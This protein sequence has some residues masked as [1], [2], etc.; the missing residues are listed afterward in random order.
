MRRDMIQ[1]LTTAVDAGNRAV[2]EGSEQYVISGERNLLS[3]QDLSQDMNRLRQLLRIAAVRRRRRTSSARALSMFASPR[4]Y[5]L[6][7]AS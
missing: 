3:L 7:S 2:S 4:R 1:L 6:R 5:A